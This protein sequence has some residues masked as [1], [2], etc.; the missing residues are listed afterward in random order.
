MEYQII[1]NKAS[2]Q[3]LS[4][5]ISRTYSCARWHIMVTHR[6]VSDRFE[7]RVIDLPVI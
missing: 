3:R 6:V 4:V 7:L 1:D 2:H 5:I